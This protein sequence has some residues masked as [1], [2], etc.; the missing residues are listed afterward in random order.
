MTGALITTSAS[1]L[2]F[3]FA[4]AIM[5]RNE[6]PSAVAAASIMIWLAIIGLGVALD[7]IVHAVIG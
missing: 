3:I 5:T 4:A 7:A 6:R 2:V 1:L